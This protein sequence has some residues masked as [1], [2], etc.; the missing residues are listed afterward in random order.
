MAFGTGHHS[1][2]SNMITHILNL[3]LQDKSVI[4]MGT[5]T[6]IL[7]ILCCMK[8]AKNV[9]GIEID[10]FAYENAVENV[11]LNGCT[12]TM[13][14]GDANVLSNLKPVDI[15]MSNINR[16]VILEDLEKYASVLKKNG[17]M[18]LSGFY[19]SDIPMIENAAF[20]YGL[21]LEEVKENEEWVALRLVKSN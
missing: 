11:R 1:T 3:D 15:F 12:A 10:P 7:A 16:N 13:I 2:T 17:I 9:T 4:D 8:G 21:C 18:L 6:G 5:G 20:G 14:C 19:K